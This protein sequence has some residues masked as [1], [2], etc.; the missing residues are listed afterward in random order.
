MSIQRFESTT[1]PFYWYKQS[2]LILYNNR[3]YEMSRLDN[4][5]LKTFE[6]VL[7]MDPVPVATME[8]C[9]RR[10]GPWPGEYFLNAVYDFEYEVSPYFTAM[11]SANRLLGFDRGFDP[12]NIY[13]HFTAPIKKIQCLMRKRARARLQPKHLA[14]AM[15]THTRLGQTSLI[16]RLGLD[17]LRM[18]LGP[19]G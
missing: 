2:A 16:Q 14:L 10:A 13:D 3:V 5:N 9:E 1:G 18:C 4:I 11:F 12:N 6:V 17:L 19:L 7:A 8:C 15:C